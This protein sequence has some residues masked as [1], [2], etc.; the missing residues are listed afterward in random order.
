MSN[1]YYNASGWPIT[2]SFGASVSGRSEMSSIAAGFDKMVALT[3]NAS[4][5]IRVNAGATAQ[6][7]VSA[8]GTG[9]VVLSNAP[10]I[11]GMTVTGNQVFSGTALRVTG[12]FNNATRANRMMF[13]NSS[14]N[15][16]SF[17]GAVPDGSGTFGAW[18]AFGGSDPD[19][20]NYGQ[21]RASS[22]EVAL[23]STKNGTGTTQPLNFYIDSTLYM[24]LT[25]AGI[26]VINGGGL[27]FPATQVPSAD[28][29][30]LDDYEEGTWTPVLTFDTAGDLAVSFPVQRGRY[31]KIGKRVFIDFELSCT[32]FTFT[33]SS[34]YIRITGLPF[35]P[36][37]STTSYGAL[38]FGGI[39]K[40]GYTQFTAN[41]N[42]SLTYLRIACAGS[43]QAAT[44]VGTTDV[45]S[46]T[47]LTLYGSVSFDV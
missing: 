25:T 43:G 10:T 37:A 38:N 13:K 2:L 7:A 47:T 11:A 26:L 22:G 30:T 32:P 5:F 34:G 19:N 21:L 41:A 16:S 35:T 3:G 33:T 29:N 27:K 12:D 44:L 36:A 8:T 24:A 17:V 15:A 6:E 28:A 18:D 46:G 31:V 4:K 14:S 20:A 1:D 23:V 42:A 40:S 39:T 9:N 45:A